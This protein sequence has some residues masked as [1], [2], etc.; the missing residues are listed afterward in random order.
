MRGTALKDLLQILLNER[1]KKRLVFFRA[2]CEGSERWYDI[3]GEMEIEQETN[4]R[5]VNAG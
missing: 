2:D 1:K 3:G 4:Y 5:E